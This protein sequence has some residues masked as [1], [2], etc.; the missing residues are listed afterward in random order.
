MDVQVLFANFSFRNALIAA[1]ASRCPAARSPWPCSRGDLVREQALGR[2][3][4]V[5][6]REPPVVPGGHLHVSLQTAELGQHCDAVV[7]YQSSASPAAILRWLSTALTD[8]SSG[9]CTSCVNSA[10]T[11]V[12]FPVAV[13]FSVFT[14][15]LAVRLVQ[16]MSAGTP[17]L[18]S[19]AR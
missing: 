9:V 16:L 1:Q 4:D 15:L 13:K 12:V 7:V 10:S 11:P 2:A 5:V 14:K 17:P 8:L 3:G 6:D 18:P 19:S